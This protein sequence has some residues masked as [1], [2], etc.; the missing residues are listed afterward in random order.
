MRK[1]KYSE[2]MMVYIML[3]IASNILDQITQMFL[4]ERNN[5]STE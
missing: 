5:V 4:Q 1:N 2:K 3:F